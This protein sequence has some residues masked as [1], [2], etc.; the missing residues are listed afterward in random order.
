VSK[1]WR[2]KGR[3][4]VRHKRLKGLIKRLT[5]VLGVDP[6]VEQAFLETARFGTWTLLIV[7]K[8]TLA[9]EVPRPDDL[10]GE[11]RPAG[12]VLAFA[13][14]RGVIEWDV[15]VRWCAVDAGAIPFLMNG[16]DCMGAG[17]H[18]ADPAVQRGDLVWIR[19]Q[20][21]GKPLA[22]GW[23]LLSGDEMVETVKGKAVRTIHWVGDELWNIGL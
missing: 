13:T 15:S 10:A 20:K 22:L 4:P 19:D 12:E 11:G 21:H 14:L 6:E 9:V 23:A 17:I 7:D 16:A 8:K 5:E 3:K 2:V 18:L 1:E